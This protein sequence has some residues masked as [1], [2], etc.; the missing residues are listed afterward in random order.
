MTFR[1]QGCTENDEV[2]GDTCVD[3]VHRAHG[4][5]SIAED[6]LVRIGVDINLGCWVCSCK[7]RDDMLDHS[8]CVIW[9]GSNSV[10]CKCM[11]VGGVEDIPTV[12]GVE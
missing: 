1:A 7:I 5:T 4:T 11:D 10:F 2:F 12:L 6:P 3:D 8:C 9:G